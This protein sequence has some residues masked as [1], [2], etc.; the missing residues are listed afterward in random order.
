MMY[1]VYMVEIEIGTNEK[2]QR[3]DRFLRKYLPGAPLSH[4]Y[5]IIR[6][7]AKVN[8]KRVKDDYSLEEGD[9][10]RLYLTDEEV[11]A[12]RKQETVK[13]V[14]RTFGIAYEDDDVLIA[15]KPAGLLTHGDRNEKS[16]HLTNQVK[17]YLME[18]G[19]YDPAEE[20]TFAPAP[21]NR[22]DRNT[23]GLVVFAKNYDSLKKLTGYFRTREK[24]RK[25]Y[26]T[27]VLG[28]IKKETTLVGM[29]QKDEGRN[30][31]RVVPGEAEPDDAKR[32]VTHVKPVK[33]GRL[34]GM[35]N[36]LFTLA[37]IEIETGRT[38]QI[39]VQLSEAGHPLLGD[40][41]YGDPKLNKK[42]H[43]RYGI[44]HQLLTAAKLEFGDLEGDLPDL[45]GK[46]V[47]AKLP[48]ELKTIKAELK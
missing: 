2:G 17:G 21:V 20:K 34:P 19:E 38:H 32:A 46:T 30:L 3:F 18:K 27:V 42:L 47:E 48:R 15:D 37:E 29:L 39:R 36:R 10:V 13:K 31:S 23:T 9:V 35:G 25:K 16:D 41:K 22:I 44:T 7:D 14:K 40:P 6:K 12:F 11:G 24:I 8:L 43:D 33:T 45:S 26:L 28:E 1:N 4:I 5:R